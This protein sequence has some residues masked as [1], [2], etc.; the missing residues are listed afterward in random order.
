MNRKLSYIA[1]T[2][3]AIVVV[4]MLALTP[5]RAAEKPDYKAIADRIV[6]QS[7]NVKEGDRVVVRGD[8]RD[9]DLV[10]EVVLAVW[11]HGGEPLQVIRREKSARRYFDEVPAQRDA[12]PLG[13]SLKLADVETVEINISGQE[14]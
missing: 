9:I 7:A 8:I 1:A 2:H 12:M 13:F 4:G 5:L 14:F 10:E 3:C 11:K 6:G